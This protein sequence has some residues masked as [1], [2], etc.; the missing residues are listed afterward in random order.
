MSLRMQRGCSGMVAACYK[1]AHWNAR[2]VD[3][4]QQ[5][6]AQQFCNAAAHATE[7]EPPADW[8]DSCVCVGSTFT[9]PDCGMDHHDG[10]K[11]LPP[12]TPQAPCDS[13]SNG[14]PVRQQGGQSSLMVL[15]SMCCDR[16]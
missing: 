3:Q 8:Q 4:L 12:A 6:A 5:E 15:P 10:T 16:A 13:G 1:S 14:A 7:L 11:L 9:H 2:H